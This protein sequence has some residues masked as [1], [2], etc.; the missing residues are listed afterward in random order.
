M[1]NTYTITV[2]VRDRNKAWISLYQVISDDQRETIRKIMSG[3]GDKEKPEKIVKEKLRSPSSSLEVTISNSY[4]N[5]QKLF[6]YTYKKE[7]LNL[8]GSAMITNWVSQRKGG[9]A[10][11][12][13]KWNLLIKFNTHTV[14]KISQR[15]LKTKKKCCGIVCYNIGCVRGD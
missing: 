15:S 2:S 14:K 4:A 1:N 5:G 3:Y 13:W 8:G 12:S 10:K 11:F 9:K 6:N 7:S